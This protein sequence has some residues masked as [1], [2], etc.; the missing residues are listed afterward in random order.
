MTEPYRPPAPVP[1]IGSYGCFGQW[2]AL[3]ALIWV[4]LHA[5]QILVFLDR[6]LA[7]HP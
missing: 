1:P 2:L 4:I 7:W 5:P 6:L 3:L